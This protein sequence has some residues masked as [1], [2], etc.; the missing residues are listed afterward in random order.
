MTPVYYDTDNVIMTTTPV[1]ILK[2]HNAGQVG[3]IHGDLDNLNP[4]VTKAWVTFPHLSFPR[5]LKSY[6][7]TSLRRAHDWEIERTRD[8]APRA[9]GRQGKVAL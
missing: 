5:D 1:Y 7:L 4:G 2:G 6:R 3:T 9:V 8:P